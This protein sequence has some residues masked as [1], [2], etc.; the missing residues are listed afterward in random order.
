MILELQNVSVGYGRKGVVHDVSF[1]VAAGDV[2]CLLGPNGS[3]KTTLFRAILGLLPLQAGQVH[4]D[5]KPSG[6][7]SR[8]EFARRIA[9]VPQLHIPPFP[10]TVLDVVSMGRTPFIGVC[11]APGPA[12]REAAESVLDR[13][14]IRHLRDRTYTEISGGERQ[15]VLIARALA[16][17][18]KL[19]VMDEPTSHLDYGNQVRTVARI[20]DLAR[21]DIAV[22]LTTHSPEH[23]FACATRVVALHRGRLI[24]EGPPPAVVTQELLRSLYGVEVRIVDAPGRA[25]CPSADRLLAPVFG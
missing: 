13:L 11:S 21:H 8:Q 5:G 22:V 7:W 23:A 16:Q 10:Y 12:D 4:L 15:L 18:P 24:A 3:G 2:V 20:R 6:S 9:Y 17:E 1:A 19:L 25:T 14:A